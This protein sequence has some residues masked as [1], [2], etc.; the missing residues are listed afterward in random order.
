MMHS[1][2]EFSGDC[3]IDSRSSPEGLEL[4]RGYQWPQP[5]GMQSLRQFH[6]LAPAD[7][8][9]AAPPATQTARTARGGLLGKLFGRG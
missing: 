6:I 3:C 4:L 2:H 8:K 9:I 7:Y 5:E 1:G